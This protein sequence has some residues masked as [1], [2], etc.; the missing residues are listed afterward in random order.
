MILKIK[1]NLL[2]I[3]IAAVFA[4]C[5]D[6]EPEIRK[7][8]NGTCV[9]YIDGVMRESIKVDASMPVDQNRN[10][11]HLSSTFIESDTTRI[12]MAVSTTNF[13]IPVRPGEYV[14]NGNNPSVI[15]AV[16]VYL[17]DDARGPYFSQY[18]PE[19]APGKVVITEVDEFNKLVSGTFEAKLLRNSVIV[20]MTNGSFKNIR[21]TD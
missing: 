20:T 18:V 10:I 19:A 3:F 13:Y 21:Y 9:V 5:K 15:S 12:D 17:P 1:R 7:A 8:A 14:V 4:C 11:L 6:V 2:I 16:I